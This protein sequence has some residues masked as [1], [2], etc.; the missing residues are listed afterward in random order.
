MRPIAL[1]VFALLLSASGFAQDKTANQPNEKTVEWVTIQVPKFP[2]LARTARIF[3]RVAVEV[4][5]KGCDLDIESPRVVSGHSI[6]SGAALE[7]AKH[8]TIRCGDFTN[9]TAIL[10]YEFGEYTARSC[11]AGMP[12]VMVTG[13]RVLVQA[14]A[15]C[16]NE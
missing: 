5:F 6:L 3:G 2:P 15:P 12:K 14:P 13:N 8:S 9:S 4:R 10:S 11:N 16:I 1:L 7:A